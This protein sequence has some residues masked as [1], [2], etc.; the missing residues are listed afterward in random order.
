MEILS[1]IPN[2][3]KYVIDLNEYIS[4]HAASF[5]E[6]VNFM[7]FDGDDIKNE[8]ESQLDEGEQNA[9]IN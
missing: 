1:F 8:E 5:P 4:M 3:S 2:I 9:S 7:G 6:L